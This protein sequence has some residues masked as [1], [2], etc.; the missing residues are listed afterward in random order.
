MLLALDG[1]MG[2]LDVFLTKVGGVQR[3][4]HHHKNHPE[5]ICKPKIVGRV[6][7]T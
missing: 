6:P 7:M 3:D 1:G 5:I 2:L 4:Y